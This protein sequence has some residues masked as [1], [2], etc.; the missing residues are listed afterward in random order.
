MNVK[1]NRRA[2]IERKTVTPNA[3][4]GSAST[5]WS[6]VAVVWAEVLDELPSRSESIKSGLHLS[7]KQARLRIRY[8]GG[9]DSSMRVIVDGRIYEIISDFAEIKNREYLECML[10][11]AL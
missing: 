9:L 6:L 11:T 1:L 5:A 8:R 10:E 3:T 4:F 2:R 7:K